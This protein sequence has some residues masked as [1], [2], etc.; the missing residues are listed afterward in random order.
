M[1]RYFDPAVY[2][3]ILVD[4]RG[5]GESSKTADISENTTYDL[6]T[7]FEKIRVH[8]GLCTYVCMHVCA[9]TYVCMYVYVCACVYVC[10]RVNVCVCVCVCVFMHV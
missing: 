10:L 5:C 2:K 8:L 3:I 4:Q 7:D 9:C 1:A 6:V